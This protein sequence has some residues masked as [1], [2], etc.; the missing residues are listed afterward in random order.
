MENTLR[1]DNLVVLKGDDGFMQHQ[2]EFFPNKYYRSIKLS[3]DDNAQILVFGEIFTQTQF[4]EKFE[5]ATDRVLKDWAS[6]G[7]IKVDGGGLVKALSF[8]AFSKLA[9]I[10]TY[11]GYFMGRT[12]KMRIIL[13]RTCKEIMYGFY[14]TNATKLNDLRESYQ[15]YLDTV[16]G[17]DEYLDDKS[18]QFGNRGIALSYGDLGVHKKKV[19]PF[20]L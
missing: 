20:V 10:H 16:G 7:L 18:I 1:E 17:K 15:W 14:P 5:Y 19:E 12:T 6:I 8:T 9:D 3:E 11:K 2:S 4:D 13:F